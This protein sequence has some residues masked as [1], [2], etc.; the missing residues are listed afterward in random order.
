VYKRLSSLWNGVCYKRGVVLYL[1]YSEVG[2]GLSVSCTQ[3]SSL[4]LSSTP[5]ESSRGCQVGPAGLGMWPRGH[6]LLQGRSGSPP[7][8]GSSCVASTMMVIGRLGPAWLWLGS[9]SCCTNML[10]SRPTLHH[11]LCWALVLRVVTGF[12]LN[13]ALFRPFGFILSVLPNP[14]WYDSTLGS[15]NS[16]RSL[17]AK[18]GRGRPAGLA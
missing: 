1:Y 18:C 3:V 12:D 9:A 14:P 6:R 4:S 13:L 5:R 7:E 10:S 11:K 8:V 15:S 2:N 17:M 16:P